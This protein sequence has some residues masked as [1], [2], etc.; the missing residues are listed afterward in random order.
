[1]AIDCP[2][3]PDLHTFLS[4]NALYDSETYPFGDFSWPTQTSADNWRLIGHPLSAKAGELLE[5]RATACA[6]GASVFEGMTIGGSENVC[7]SA[8]PTW[9]VQQPGAQ[10]AWQDYKSRVEAFYNA[11]AKWLDTSDPS[12]INRLECYN[13]QDLVSIFGMLEDF[14]DLEGKL[15]TD[16]IA[17]LQ[18]IADAS[19]C[20][21]LQAAATDALYYEK[22]R[23]EN[24][25][26]YI[27]ALNA[28]DAAGPTGH[29]LYAWL[30]A[31]HLED[32]RECVLALYS[33]DQ[34][35]TAAGK[36]LP[37]SSAAELQAAA[38]PAGVVGLKPYAIAA[39]SKK[40]TSRLRTENAAVPQSMAPPPLEKGK[41]VSAELSELVDQYARDNEDT[42]AALEKAG[43]EE[44]ALFLEQCAANQSG[45]EHSEMLKWWEG[46][47][48]AFCP[49]LD[50]APPPEEE[51]KGNLAIVLGVGGLLVGGPVGGL[52]GGALGAWLDQRGGL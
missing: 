6:A 32:S 34:E 42:A 33:Y 36:P 14:K 15:T 8:A 1:M 30:V 22:G 5:S 48:R 52:A 39:K 47:Q 2:V 37:E 11:Y 45:P 41:E 12:F 3:K 51:K 24:L 40:V 26:A 21:Y 49:P 31:P 19:V 38:S 4:G 28:L 25:D 46:G 18:Q 43:R 17:L 23:D 50:V 29:G 9:G 10:E 20:P 35:M 44:Y 16:E 13:N 7:G 27:R